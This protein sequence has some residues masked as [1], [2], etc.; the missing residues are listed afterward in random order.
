VLKEVEGE[1]AGSRDVVR[2]EDAMGPVVLVRCDTPLRD[3]AS[4]LLGRGVESAVVVDA[5]GTVRGVVTEHHLTLNEHYLRLACVRV[6]ELNGRWVAPADEVEAARI[7]ARTISAAEIME[8]RFS[9]AKFGEPL[10]VVVER[11][12]RRDAEYALV[13]RD[14]VAVGML[15]RRDLL[16]VLVDGSGTASEVPMAVPDLKVVATAPASSGFRWSQW[17]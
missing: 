11:M 6:P 5:G 3:V 15:G 17:K 2:V 10:S 8:T 1:P 4:V 7:A 13:W 14:G 12:V 16:T 9:A